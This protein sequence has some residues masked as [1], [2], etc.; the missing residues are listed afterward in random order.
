MVMEFL[1]YLVL[2]VTVLGGMLWGSTIK[3]SYYM[4]Y[5]PGTGKLSN[6]G[7]SILGIGII[8]LAILT[9]GM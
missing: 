6:L 8:L 9:M 7:A 2:I 3:N 1:F 5:K 4:T